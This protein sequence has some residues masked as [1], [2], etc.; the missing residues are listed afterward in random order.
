MEMQTFIAQSYTVSKLP[1]IIILFK[2]WLF[3]ATFISQKKKSRSRE[4]RKIISLYNIEASIFS[5]LGEHNTPKDVYDHSVFENW[6]KL[7]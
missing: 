7:Q 3:A 2:L 6:E 1:V 5:I 4:M